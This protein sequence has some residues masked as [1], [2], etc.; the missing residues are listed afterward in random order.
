VILQ[1]RVEN[2][3]LKKM[4]KITPVKKVPQINFHESAYWL[5]PNLI[6]STQ[7]NK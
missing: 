1:L 5:R 3:H 7:A 6:K 4:D 2:V